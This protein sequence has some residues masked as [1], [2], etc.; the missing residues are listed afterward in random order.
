MALHVIGHHVTSGALLHCLIFCLTQLSRHQVNETAL[1][2]WLSNSPKRHDKYA[3]WLAPHL[4]IR[5]LGR[6][7]TLISM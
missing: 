1:N 6:Y 4:V 7:V 2:N 3:K 5:R